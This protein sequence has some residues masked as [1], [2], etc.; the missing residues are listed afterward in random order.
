MKTKI[1][2]LYIIGKHLWEN[3]WSVQRDQLSKG[4]SR[5]VRDTRIVVVTLHNYNQQKIGFQTCALSFQCAVA[6]IPMLAILFAVTGGFGLS[7]PLK[8]LLYE[9]IPAEP[10]L[11]DMIMLAAENIVDAAQSGLFGVIS[12]LTFIWAILWLFMRVEEVFNNVWNVKKAKRNI[13]KRI[14]VDI[15]IMLT[16]PMVIVIFFAGQVVYSH[17]LDVLIPDVGDITSHLKN[18][19]NWAILAGV[20]VMTLSSMYK[21]IPATKV[22]YRYALKSALIAG[23]IFTGLQ[24]LYLETQVMVT[25]MNAFY[26]TVA[27]VPLFLIWLNYSWQIILYGAQFSYAFQKV[28]EIESKI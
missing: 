25:T 14:G 8:Y 9:K 11:I 20:V 26:G 10:E 5:L 19:L 18:F 1:M 21:F 7:D 3:L 4:W 23:I 15:M 16:I 28:D 22:H 6:L 12:V 27:A 2:R 24:Y 13:F 17:V